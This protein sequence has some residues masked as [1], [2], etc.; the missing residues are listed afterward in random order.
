[1]AA[2]V[3]G[4]CAL[5]ACSDRLDGEPEPYPFTNEDMEFTDAADT[6]GSDAQ[7]NY[8]GEDYA[9]EDSAL[10][11]G[12][13]ALYAEEEYDDGPMSTEGFDPTP[14]DFGGIDPEPADF[15]S[16]DASLD[17]DNS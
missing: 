14:V 9:D 15:D 4:A 13:D 3:A 11:D 6:S 17:A 16:L 7:M 12:E 8:D 2:V 10:E 5:T 1:M